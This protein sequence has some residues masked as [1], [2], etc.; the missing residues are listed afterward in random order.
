MLDC[1][2]TVVHCHSTKSP[3]ILPHASSPAQ[4]LLTSLKGHCTLEA[5]SLLF[6]PMES[7]QLLCCLTVSA[8]AYFPVRWMWTCF[9][10][11][12][13]F[14]VHFGLPK[15]VW[16]ATWGSSVIVHSLHLI[17]MSLCFFLSWCKH[18]AQIVILCTNN[19][20]LNIYWTQLCMC[21]LFWLPV[22]K[23]HLIL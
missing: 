10:Y 15:W 19:A 23:V 22:N 11:L 13:I 9:K 16:F 8:V 21:T 6:W 12:Y 5:E 4:K 2:A 20:Y 1:R 7:L 17:W 14:R 3:A 18:W